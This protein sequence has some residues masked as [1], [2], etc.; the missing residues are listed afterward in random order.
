[1][2]ANQPYPIERRQRQQHTRL[3]TLML[4]AAVLP[5]APLSFV[6]SLRLQHK[7]CLH[8]HITAYQIAHGRLI[9][10]EHCCCCWHQETQ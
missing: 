6:K 3:E 9:F 8:L 1:M 10:N 5:N 4:P 2:P 7:V